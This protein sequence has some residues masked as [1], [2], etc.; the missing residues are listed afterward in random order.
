MNILLDIILSFFFKRNMM[1]HH[2][3]EYA[4][5]DILIKDG[6]IPLMSFRLLEGSVSVYSK[7]RFIAEYGP[8]TCWGAHEIMND[9]PSLYTVWIRKGS[10][11]CAIGKSELQKTWMKIIS[12][13]D[14][15]ILQSL[16]CD[17]R[18]D[19]SII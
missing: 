7:H 11:V 5:D 16:N 9:E 17:Q 4:Q 6:H 8:H 13:F 2:I 1:C 3:Y 10:K 19:V 12:L 15:D 18:S 14:H